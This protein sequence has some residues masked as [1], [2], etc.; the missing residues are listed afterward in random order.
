MKPKTVVITGASSGIGLQTALELG[1]R[2]HRMVL[3]ARRESKLNEV[4]AQVEGMGGQAKVVALDVTAYDAPTALLQ[5]AQSF[6]VEARPVLVHNAGAASFGPTHEAPLESIESQIDLMMRAPIRLTHAFLPWMLEQGEGHL[7]NILS[8]VT[9]LTFP[10]AAAYTGA[11]TGLEGFMRS[12]QAEVRR[13]GIR[14][15]N[16]QPGATDTDIWG[17]GGPNRADMVPAS[18]IARIIADVIESPDDRSID[19][20]VITP[21]KGV[22]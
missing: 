4:A 6:G 1:L 20:I 3:A 11:K 17:D 5:A 7:I 12:L 14:V 19:E 22:L 10:N 13:K 9:K 8:I 21:P 18:A 16:I 2:G 15:T